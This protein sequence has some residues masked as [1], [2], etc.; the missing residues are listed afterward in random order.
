MKTNGRK[1]DKI[2][3]KD[4][5]LATEAD[6][7]VKGRTIMRQREADDTAAVRADEDQAL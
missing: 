7:R 5:H 1:N 4:K 6:V 3:E 2:G